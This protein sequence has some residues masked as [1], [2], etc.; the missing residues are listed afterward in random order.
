MK[1]CCVFLTGVDWRGLL[2]ETDKWVELWSGRLLG[3]VLVGR[4]STGWRTWELWRDV[5]GEL[6]MIISAIAQ[7]RAGEAG[8]LR[9]TYL[10]KLR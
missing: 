8:E 2:V 10:L 9:C 3:V 4:S 7:K 6:V 5:D 1:V